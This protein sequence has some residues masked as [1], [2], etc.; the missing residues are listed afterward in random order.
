MK[1]TFAVIASISTLLGTSAFAADVPV[2]TPAPPPAIYDWTGF[3]IGGNVGWEN[4]TSNG[5]VDNRGANF[6]FVNGLEGS[7]YGPTNQSAQGWLGG[8]QFGYNYQFRRAVVGLEISGS[9]TDVKGQ[10]AAIA[11][12][13]LAPPYLGPLAC[14]GLFSN[15]SNSL[16]CN[17]RQDWNVQALAKLGYTFADGRLFP[18]LTA[19]VA[20]T[21]MNDVLTVGPNP[22]VINGQTISFGGDRILPGVVLGAGAQYALGNGFSIGAE[23]LFTAYPNQDF[24]SLYQCTPFGGGVCPVPGGPSVNAPTTGFPVQQNHDLVTNAVRVVVNY[25][26][27]D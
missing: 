3:Y 14:V 2:K 24:T 15:S 10:S 17:L 1:K 25:K 12:F 13:G 4:A 16:S 26:F 8:A 7:E 6:G 5:W 21:H 19:G 23:Y 22:A 20:V 9:W 27:G 11:P 18:Y